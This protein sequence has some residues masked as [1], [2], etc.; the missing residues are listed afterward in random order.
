MHHSG[1]A[2][3]VCQSKT[4]ELHHLKTKQLR[5]KDDRR[6]I[7]LCHEHHRGAEFSVH[8]TPTYFAQKYS[9]TFLLQTAANFY[10]EYE[11][12]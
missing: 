10:F 6:V 2:C 9:M 8:G 5:T 11:N 1:K 4:I 3:I 12:L 7:P